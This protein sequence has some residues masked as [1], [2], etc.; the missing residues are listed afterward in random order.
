MLDKIGIRLC[1]GTR[2]G[3]SSELTTDYNFLVH[4]GKTYEEVGIYMLK[5]P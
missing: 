4:A 3:V 1:T 5:F 2:I